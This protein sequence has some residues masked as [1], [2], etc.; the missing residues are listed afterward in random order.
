MKRSA[1]LRPQ[2]EDATL[3]IRAR[4]A[5]NARVVVDDILGSLARG[6]LKAGDQL[7]N[8][9]DLCSRYEMPRH[10]VRKAMDLLERRGIIARFVGRGSFIVNAAAGDADTPQAGAANLPW[11]LAELTEARL[12]FEL[13]LAQLMVERAEPRDLELAGE[14][15]QAIGAAR[16]WRSFKESKYAFHL[17]LVRAAGNGFLTHMFELLIAC[18]R[19]N[20]WARNLPFT[21]GL[22]L[23]KSVCLQESKAVLDA[24]RQ[25]D[26]AQAGAALHKSLMR[27]MVSLSVD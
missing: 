14:C 4:S 19:S 6:G 25:R 8:E 17:A 18:R 16:D 9:R 3:N 20:A 2:P 24:L 1:K 7:P 26:A 27:I 15:L 10:T 12:L 11:S 21:D 22:D 5:R 23:A 13:G